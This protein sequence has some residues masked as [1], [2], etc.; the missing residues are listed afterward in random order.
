MGLCE[1]WDVRIGIAQIFDVDGR[2]ISSN[3]KHDTA[4]LD[5]ELLIRLD[6]SAH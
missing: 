4:I 3:M 5:F 1:T 6:K 2:L